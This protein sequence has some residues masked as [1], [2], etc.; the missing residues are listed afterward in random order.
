MTAREFR[1]RLLKRLRRHEIVPSDT[2]IKALET[3]FSLLVRWNARINLTALQLDPPDEKSFDR[4]LVEPL[5]AA[6]FL[7]EGGLRLIDI[8]SGSGS[9]AIPLAVA[10]PDAALTMVESKTRKAVFLMEV[11][12][13]LGLAAVVETARFEHLLARPDLH[14]NFDALSI[15]AVRVESRTLLSLQAFLKADA[16]LFWFSSAPAAILSKVPPP[17]RVVATHRLVESAPSH[18]VI[19]TKEA[20][21]R[22]AMFHVE[23]STLR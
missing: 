8:G 11:V 15:R 23:R 12:R 17:L 1:L 21:G 9:P 5:L 18:L 3:Y 2:L 10:R 13:A 22:G 7:H 6:R 19:L 14:E 4:L 20:V 16:R